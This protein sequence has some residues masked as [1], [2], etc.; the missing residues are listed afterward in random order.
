VRNIVTDNF[1]F[2][3]VR[4]ITEM[5]HFLNKKIVAEF[6]SSPEILEVVSSIGV[7]Y[8]QGFHIGRPILLDDLQLNPGNPAN[9]AAR[10]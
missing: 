6:V 7:D 9:A 5:G 8:A 10:L 2:A 4:S 3:L 1:D